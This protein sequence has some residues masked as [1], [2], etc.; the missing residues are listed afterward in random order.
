MNSL[1]RAYQVELPRPERSREHLHHVG[2]GV[3]QVG[4]TIGVEEHAVFADGNVHVAHDDA[5]QRDHAS[6][7]VVDVTPVLLIVILCVSRP[8]LT[9][10]VLL[11]P[12][13]VDGRVLRGDVGAEAT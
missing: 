8:L 5:T 6:Q 3:E 10:M 9:H 2:A 4:D 1:L 12:E 7:P 11:A 13:G